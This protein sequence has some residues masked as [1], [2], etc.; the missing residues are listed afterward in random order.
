MFIPLGKPKFCSIIRDQ[1]FSFFTEPSA[2]SS[3]TFS[4]KLASELLAKSNELAS[5]HHLRIFSHG[6]TTLKPLD[7]KP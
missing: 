1:I 6:G 3:I 4:F 5:H 7:C 2:T